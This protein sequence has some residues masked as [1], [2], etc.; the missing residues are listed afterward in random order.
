M[1]ANTITSVMMLSGA[2]TASNGMFVTDMR[3]FSLSPSSPFS[4]NG[5]VRHLVPDARLCHQATASI[6]A[7]S[8]CDQISLS[9]SINR[10]ISPS[11]C[12]GDGVI[13]S[14]SVP[15]GTVG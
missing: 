9:A 12:T 15:T 10:P 14:R 5:L 7:S 11:V 2:A 13:R 1:I 4:F 3:D 8:H 6:R